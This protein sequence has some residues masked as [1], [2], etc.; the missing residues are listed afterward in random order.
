MMRKERLLWGKSLL[1]IVNFKVSS[2]FFH[3]YRTP[4][5]M[6]PEVIMRKNYGKKVDVW[7]L[8]IM[9]IEMIHGHPPY[10]D[11]SP[12]HAIYM[13]AAKGRPDIEDWDKLSPDM[14]NFL[15]RCLEVDQEK[16]ASSTDLMDH[17]FLGL[18]SDL[19]FLNE[20]IECAKNNQFLIDTG[21]VVQNDTDTDTLVCQSDSS[22][23][24]NT[25]VH[26]GDS[27][28]ADTDTLVYQSE[29]SESTNTMIHHPESNGM[30]EVD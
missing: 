4:Y 21:G 27:S 29:S 14:Q 18:A 30:D 26:Q 13:I 8:G 16:R 5:W 25:A 6:A 19:S 3:C 23:S 1:L 9:V 2:L 22:E 11:E 20:S 10:I 17:P 28:D 15:D 24:K 7:S 12:V